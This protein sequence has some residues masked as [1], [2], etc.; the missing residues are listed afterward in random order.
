M[1]GTALRETA[2]PMGKPAADYA[3]G[4]VTQEGITDATPMGATPVAGGATFRVWA[5]QELEVHLRLARTGQVIN[6]DVAFTP[7]D[8]TRLQVDAHGHWTG[9][10][11]G[12]REGDHYRFHLVGHRQ[13]LVRDPYARELE[14]HDWPEVDCIIRSPSSYFWHDHGFRTPWFHEAVIYQLHFGTW[15]AVDHQGRDAR[16]NRVAKFLDAVERIPYLADLGVNFIQ[17]LPVTEFNSVPNPFDPIPRSLGYNGTDLFSPEMDY[18]VEAPDLPR[19]LETVNRLLMDRGQP[20]LQLVDLEPQINQLKVF[21]DLC[22][23]YG[24]AVIFDAVYNHAGGF[25]GDEQSLYQFRDE[26][27]GKLYFLRDGWAGGLVFDFQNPGVRQFLIDNARF[28]L[29]EY[30]VDGFRYDEVSVIDRFGG[31]HFCQDLTGTV[32][33]HRPASL[34]HAEYWNDQ[35]YWAVRSRQ[36]NGAGFDTVLTTGIRDAVRGAIRQAAGGREAVV[37]LSAVRD[38]L[39]K[40]NGFSSVSQVVQCLETHDRQRVQNDNDREPR[41][42]ALADSTNSRSWYARSRARVANGLLLTAPGLPMLFMG[43]EFLEDKYWTDDPDN[44]PGNLIWWSGLDR[45]RAMQDHLRFTRDLIWLRR[46]HSALQGELVNPY[47]VHNHNRILA[48]HR[49]IEGVGRDVVIV[50]SLNEETFEHYELGMPRSGHWFEVFNSDYF[51]HYPNPEVRGNG[52]SIA[53]YSRPR[54]GMSASATICLP[55]NSLL[56]FALERGD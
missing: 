4:P 12:A 11:A 6:R 50:T 1:M 56:V 28:F 8:A 51:D 39:R 16:S 45:D 23:L 44:H 53:A 26:R 2:Q 49:W 10:V 47:Y 37:N 22:H 36:D 19:Y 14:F 5:P 41:I 24:M 9:F 29:D 13:P 52:G 21:V 33:H 3:F 40:P 43:Q 27:G 48:I 30:H 20:P 25:F 18:G 34:H 46:R 42:A 35:P 31:W 32:K 55:A 17:P 38:S 15:H 7:T 54:D